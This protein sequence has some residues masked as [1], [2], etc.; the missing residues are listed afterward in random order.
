V[1][2]H[3]AK[4]INIYNK[5][6]MEYQAYNAITQEAEAGSRLGQPVHTKNL[7]LENK[8]FPTFTA[9]FKSHFSVLFCFKAT[10][11]VHWS[12]A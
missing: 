5:P 7:S 9:T 3:I 2:I 4:D 6:G 12:G 10:V 1:I 8:T 11:M